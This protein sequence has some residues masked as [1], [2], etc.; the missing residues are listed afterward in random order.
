M[1]SAPLGDDEVDVITYNGELAG[2]TTM[3]TL[4]PEQEGVIVILSNNNTPY[5]SLVGLTLAFAEHAFGG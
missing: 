5:P 2:T 1:T 3:L 4:F